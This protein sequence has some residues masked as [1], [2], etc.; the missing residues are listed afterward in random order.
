MSG[1]VCGSGLGV[2]LALTFLKGGWERKGDVASSYSPLWVGPPHGRTCASFPGNS[3]CEVRLSSGDSHC[4]CS[5]LS[6]EVSCSL[7]PPHEHQAVG[8]PPH[9]SC[10]RL[11]S[12]VP[13]TDGHGREGEVTTQGKARPFLL[14]P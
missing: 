11:K 14:P 7:L 12:T 2:A 1:R 8:I 10:C 6:L 3:L 4:Q 9:R 13:R 5:W